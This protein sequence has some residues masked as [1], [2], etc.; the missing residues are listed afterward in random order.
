[1]GKPRCIW[2]L[3]YANSLSNSTVTRC[4]AA[5]HTSLESQAVPVTPTTSGLSCHHSHVMALL[6]LYCSV[7]ML[8]CVEE[9]GAHCEAA[10]LFHVHTA[11]K[12]STL[13]LH[14]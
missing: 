10:R 13:G 12:A 6:S 9:R 3:E 2:L 8:E 5:E 4:D 7:S 11:P 14:G 1:M